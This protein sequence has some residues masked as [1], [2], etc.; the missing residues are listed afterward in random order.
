[1]RQSECKLRKPGRARDHVVIQSVVQVLQIL[2]SKNSREGSRWGFP[3][4][5]EGFEENVHVFFWV[6]KGESWFDC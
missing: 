4:Q 1:M 3:G 2:D 6:L 5:E